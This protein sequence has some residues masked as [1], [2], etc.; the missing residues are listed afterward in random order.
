VAPTITLAAVLVLARARRGRAFLAGV[1]LGAG[2][3]VPAGI[4][5]ASLVG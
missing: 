4:A 1:A 2:L 5:L 3:L